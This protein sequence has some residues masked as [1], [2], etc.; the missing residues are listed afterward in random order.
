VYS[1]GWLLVCSWYV[2]SL[3]RVAK[4]ERRGAGMF[5]SILTAITTT[6]T[7]PTSITMQVPADLR[8]IKVTDMTVDNSNLTGEG[9]PQ[10]R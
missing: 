6:T 4:V 10:Q 1:A 3:H 5:S 7:P 2:D 9:D 8:L